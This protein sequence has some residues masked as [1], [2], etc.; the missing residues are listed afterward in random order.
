MFQIKGIDHVVI[1]ASDLGP[2]LEFYIDVLGCAL[3]RQNEE[4]G[5]Y[6]LRAGA[7]LIDLVPVG[8]VDESAV[9][10]DAEIQV[11]LNDEGTLRGRI[12]NRQNE[13]QQFATD[14]QG[15]T[16]GVG[17]SYEVDFNTFPELMQRLFQKQQQEAD[18]VQDSTL[19]PQ[20][21]GQDSLIRFYTKNQP[22]Y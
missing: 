10:G 18:M 2:M 21:M 1:R 15:Y 11:L 3:E 4:I 7:S 12:F 16:Q 20:T 9:A 22:P 17:V 6:Q 14:R 19:V 13:I 5:L 8:G